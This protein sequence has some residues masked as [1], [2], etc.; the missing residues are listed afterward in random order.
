[1]NDLVAHPLAHALAHSFACSLALPCYSHYP[2]PCIFP[3]S[4]RFL[5]LT[6]ALILCTWWSKSGNSSTRAFC[7]TDYGTNAVSLAPSH[8][9]LCGQSR[10]SSHSLSPRVS[11]LI[12]HFVGTC[13]RVSHVY[14]HCG[15]ARIYDVN[16]SDAVY[17]YLRH[18]PPI[19]GDPTS[20]NA[21][22]GWLS[23]DYRHR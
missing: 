14:K 7:Q 17:H 3:S 12:R 20:L 2:S 19:L 10:L 8:T 4:R 6:V 15:C 9:L 18:I 1:M 23:K 16:V 11:V 21:V 5:S 22:D 13:I